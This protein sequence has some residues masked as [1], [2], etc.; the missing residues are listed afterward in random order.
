MGSS[1]SSHPLVLRPLEPAFAVCRLPVEHAIEAWMQSA[2]IWSITRTPD[3]LSIVCP[4]DVVP[5]GVRREG[6]FGAFMVEGPLDFAL[7]GILSRLSGPLASAGIPIFVYF[8]RNHGRDSQLDQIFI[9]PIRAIS[10]VAGDGHGPGDW[11]AI[12]IN[13]VG[14]GAFQQCFQ[15]GR[16]VR[17]PRR[18][19]EVQRMAFAVA[20]NMD[21]CGKTPARTA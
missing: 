20:E 1:D 18:Q 10:L 14:I 5:T 2:A 9:D 7:T 17:L 12:A 4:V 8:G 19:M 13:H 16:L 21:F 11:L 6:P 3:E 15:G